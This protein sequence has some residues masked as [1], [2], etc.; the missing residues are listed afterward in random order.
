MSLKQD[1]IRAILLDDKP[2][3]HLQCEWEC[4]ICGKRCGGVEAHGTLHQCPDHY[5]I[6]QELI[7]F[8][9]SKSLKWVNGLRPYNKCKE[10]K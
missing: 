6:L 8:M 7:G 10:M 3:L 9:Q 2:R 1:I 5:P 4:P